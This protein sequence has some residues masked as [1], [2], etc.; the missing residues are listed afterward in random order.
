MGKGTGDDSIYVRL[1][2]ISIIITII[3]SFVQIWSQGLINIEKLKDIFIF[4][5]AFCVLIEILELMIKPDRIQYFIRN[6]LIALMVF[7][8]LFGLIRYVGINILNIDEVNYKSIYDK[9]RQEYRD[10]KKELDGAGNTELETALEFFQDCPKELSVIPRTSDVYDASQK[11]AEDCENEAK[12]LEATNTPNN[13]PTPNAPSS[14][15]DTDIAIYG[16]I[17]GEFKTVQR[18][19]LRAE[20]IT[21]LK[22]ALEFFQTCPEELNLISETSGAYNSSQKL[23]QDCKDKAR[24]LGDRIEEE[25][26]ALELFNGAEKMAEAA[27]VKANAAA[28]AN[29]VGEFDIDLFRASGQDI[30]DAR[31][32]LAQISKTSAPIMHKV[33]QQRI[34]DYDS[35]IEHMEHIMNNIGNPNLPQDILDLCITR[36]LPDDNCK[37]LNYSL[38]QIDLPS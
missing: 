19:L 15:N 17:N 2:T 6:I 35:I 20:G 36:F 33:A 9:N 27:I 22:T 28:N 13:S 21:E 16:G 11:L 23:A 25:E 26:A 18:D 30:K 38:P 7:L 31:Q 29:S 37:P 14:A 10:I 5:Y 8:G 4:G 32:K 24:Q 1:Q 3:T 34:E 12:Q